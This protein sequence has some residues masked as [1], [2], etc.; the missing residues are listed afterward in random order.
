MEEEES[1][2]G[3]EERAAEEKTEGEMQ[4]GAEEDGQQQQ[5]SGFLAAIQ[6]IH[7]IQ[8]NLGRM[9]KEAAAGGELRRAKGKEEEGEGGEMA[10]ADREVLEQ[11]LRSANYSLSSAASASSMTHTLRNGAQLRVHSAG[12]VTRLKPG[13]FAAF[14]RIPHIAFHHP[15]PLFLCRM[16]QNNG[17]NAGSGL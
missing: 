1:A 16:P 3:P 11:Q 15:T 17:T 12:F 5:Q 13:W 7:Q 10:P 9:L 4:G 8:Q 2:D 14:K 6:R